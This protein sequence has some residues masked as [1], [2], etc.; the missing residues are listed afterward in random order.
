MNSLSRF[1]ARPGLIITILAGLVAGHGILLYFLRHTRIPHAGFS[2]ALV[3]GVVLLVVAKHLGL[4]AALLRPLRDLFR[5][6]FR[7][8]ESED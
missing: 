5:H 7:S 8:T 4:L 1:R 6:R 3:S 2:G